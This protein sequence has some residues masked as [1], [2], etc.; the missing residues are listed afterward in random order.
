MELREAAFGVDATLVHVIARH[1]A[2]VAELDQGHRRD[3]ARV[4]LH[5]FG[6]AGG[7][8]AADLAA[9]VG[10][11]VH[12]GRAVGAGVGELCPH[13]AVIPDRGEEKGFFPGVARMWIPEGNRVGA[14]EGEEA[15]FRDAHAVPAGHRVPGGVDA[16][17]PCQALELEQVSWVVALVLD[18]HRDNGAPILPVEARELPGDLREEGPHQCE[19]GGIQAALAGAGLFDPVR[20]SA[21][22]NLAMVPRTDAHDGPQAEFAAEADKGTQVAAAAPIEMASFLLVVDPEDI[23]RHH[24][25]AAGAHPQQLGAPF[26]ARV[27]GEMKFTGHGHEGPA[28][29]QQ[30][31]GIRGQSGAVRCH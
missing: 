9:D 29:F 4:D 23:G 3:L 12:G 26:L 13:V 28:V 5:A 8:A 25:D 21:I 7:H 31:N 1:V 18:L 6:V 24:G 17:F 30:R 27:A 16:Q 14:E 2:A 22:A 11:A 10:E 15:L 20:M 19:E